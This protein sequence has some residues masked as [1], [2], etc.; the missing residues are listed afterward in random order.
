MRA[1]GITYAFASPIDTAGQTFEILTRQD[2]LSAGVAF[3]SR[4]LTGLGKDRILVL[5]NV[6]LT[7]EPGATQFVDE[8]RI[9]GVTHT[10]V[11][12]DLATDVFIHAVDEQVSLNWEG[13]IYIP[14]GGTDAD[15]VRNTANFN[16]GVNANLVTNSWHGIV[17]PRGNSAAF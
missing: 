10:G 14:G 11:I 7:A 12:F 6:T 3:F 17:I 5:T 16:A 15:F 4:V 9:Q 2:Q 8:L 1:P 13:E